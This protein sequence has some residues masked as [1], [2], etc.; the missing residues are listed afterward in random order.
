[1]FSPLFVLIKKTFHPPAP[2]HNFLYLIAVEVG[3]DAVNLG[4]PAQGH[5][6]DAAVG[7]R[8]EELRAWHA[9]VGR[10]G[11]SRATGVGR[12]RAEL[13]PEVSLEARIVNVALEKF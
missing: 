2:C 6:L 1:M 5:S 3:H 12:G 13:Q 4:G 7:A 10:G 11:R 8:V 9:R